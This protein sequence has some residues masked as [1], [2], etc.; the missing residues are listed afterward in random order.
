MVSRGLQRIGTGSCTAGRGS[1]R[2]AAPPQQRHLLR[3]LRIQPISAGLFGVPVGF[4][5]ILIVSLLTG[6]PRKDTQELVEHVC[7]PDLKRA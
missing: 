2:R 5:V 4:A 7:Y 3:V 1:G 6:Q